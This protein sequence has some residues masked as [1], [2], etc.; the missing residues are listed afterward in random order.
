VNAPGGAPI[1]RKDIADQHAR[2]I[3]E[4]LETGRWGKLKN[5]RQARNRTFRDVTDERKKQERKRSLGET[6]INTACRLVGMG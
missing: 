5:R 1:T 4:M 3:A 2:E 6:M